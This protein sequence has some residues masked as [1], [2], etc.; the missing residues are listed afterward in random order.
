MNDMLDQKE[1][2]EFQE[3][4]LLWFIN[5]ILH[6]FGWVIAYTV[7]D[8]AIIDVFPCRCK[9]RGFSE[10]NNTEGYIKVS[11]YMQK[12]IDKLLREAKDE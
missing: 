6:I 1:W 4:G 9:F 2:R 10:E 8:D 11:E 5:T 7:S 12:N 3:T